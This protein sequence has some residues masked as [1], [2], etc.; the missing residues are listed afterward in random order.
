MHNTIKLRSGMVAD[1]VKATAVA[2]RL[3]TQLPPRK[4]FATAAVKTGSA[5]SQSHLNTNRPSAAESHRQNDD[6]KTQ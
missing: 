2:G 3:T 4:V 6:C 5:V 1:D